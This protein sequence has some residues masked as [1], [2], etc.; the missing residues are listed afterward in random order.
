MTYSNI[1]SYIKKSVNK[2]SQDNGIVINEYLI[3]RYVRFRDTLDKATQLVVGEYINGYVSGVA[4]EQ[5][6]SQFYEEYDNTENQLSP[7]VK[8][9]VSKLFE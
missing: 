6:Y 7:K 4:V 5:F 8:A 3:E 2:V 9:F 1:A